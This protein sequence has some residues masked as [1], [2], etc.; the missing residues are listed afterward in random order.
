VLVHEGEYSAEHQSIECD[1]VYRAESEE[2]PRAKCQHADDDVICQNVQ[3][4]DR[5]GHDI[6]EALGPQMPPFDVLDHRLARDESDQRGKSRDDP[7][8]GKG[9]RRHQARHPGNVRAQ[10]MKGPRNV[11]AQQVE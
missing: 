6:D 7:P 1:K 11:G 8:T 3:G 9:A 10:L 5:G 2:N 4:Q